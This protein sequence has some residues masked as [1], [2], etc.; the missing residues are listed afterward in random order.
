MSLELFPHEPIG[1]KE[2]HPQAETESALDKKERTLTPEEMDELYANDGR[3]KWT[4]R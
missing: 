2:P 3:D 4:D 1:E